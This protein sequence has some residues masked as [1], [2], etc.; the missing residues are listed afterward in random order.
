MERR[1]HH[2]VGEQNAKINNVLVG[3]NYQLNGSCQNEE[4]TALALARTHY[5]NF[6]LK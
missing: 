1:L 2:E 6:A 3:V 4:H 5:S